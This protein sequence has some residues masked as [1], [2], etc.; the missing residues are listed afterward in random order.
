MQIRELD[1]LLVDLLS[2]DHPEIAKVV[3]LDKQ[4]SR[5]RVEFASGAVATITI[6]EVSGPG[7]PNH[8]PYEIPESVI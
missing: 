7:V 3:P 8:H 4:H 1:Q 5:V 6:R 2:H